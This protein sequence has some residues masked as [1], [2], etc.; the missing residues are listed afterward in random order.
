MTQAQQQVQQQQQQQAVQSGV[1][2]TGPG[3]NAA[4]PNNATTQP[5]SQVPIFEAG[6]PQQN[7]YSN[8]GPLSNVLPSDGGSGEAALAG[9][10]AAANAWLNSVDFTSSLFALK[11]LT[12]QDNTNTSAPGAPDPNNPND[13]SN[14]NNPN[15]DSG[16][17]KSSPDDIVA[18]RLVNSAIEQ[19]EQKARN[20]A[21]GLNDPND[22]NDVSNTDGAQSINTQDT[23]A[24]QLQ[25]EQGS[26]TGQQKARDAS[27][28]GGA[29]GANQPGGKSASADDAQA[30]GRPGTAV[31]GHG[32]DPEMAGELNAFLKGQLILQNPKEKTLLAMLRGEQLEETLEGAQTIL[33]SHGEGALLGGLA[34]EAASLG[35]A[36]VGELRGTLALRGEGAILAQGGEQAL[37]T[38]VMNNT[39]MLVMMMSTMPSPGNSQP[40]LA[41]IAADIF[42]LQS[43]R[44]ELMASSRC[45]DEDGEMPPVDEDEA[46]MKQREVQGVDMGGMW[47]WDLRPKVG[48]DMEEEEEE[49]AQVWFRT[50]LL[51]CAL[52][53]PNLVAPMFQSTEEAHSVRLFEQDEAQE[54]FTEH[55][56]Q[57]PSKQPGLE[58]FSVNSEHFATWVN[59]A[60]KAFT[61]ARFGP[62]PII[63]DDAAKMPRRRP[64]PC[65]PSLESRPTH[66]YVTSTKTR[67]PSAPS[68]RLFAAATRPRACRR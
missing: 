39:R 51:T 19:A 7:N 18:A 32:L 49:S 30:G 9:G 45:A 17:T 40:V 38:A 44:L 8:T 33:G 57:I 46:A 59:L 6:L 20:S 11:P 1:V 47:R 29:N 56:V 14:A 48:A 2:Q 66:W 25:Q 37:N 27:N 21:S 5:Q 13:A 3:A 58:S 15:F 26:T 4:Q 34:G 35:G 64:R 23:P 12:T 42:R 68:S 31:A 22:P 62:S 60:E 54:K 36:S 50:A 10:T 24:Q 28:P 65:K 61:H 52:Q 63:N 16:L 41:M 67:M 53:R 55:W 43:M